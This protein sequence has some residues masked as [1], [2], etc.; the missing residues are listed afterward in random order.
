VI[1]EIINDLESYYSLGYRASG[2]LDAKSQI[3]VKV[4]KGL[5][6]R[7]TLSSGAVSRDWEVADQVLANHVLEPANP[8]SISVV[9]DKAVVEGDKKT[10]P[11]KIM[12]PVN[13]LKLVPDKGEYAAAFTVFISLGDP[14]GNGSEPSRQEQSFRWPEAAVAQVKGKTIGFAVNLE[15]G[16]DRD[17]V[18]V[19]V[20]D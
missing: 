6:A 15:V 16:A 8:L 17:R 10:I 13:S 2:P 3:T 18:S 5:N 4:K 9:L 19:G 1:T 11:M 12:I 14:D 20:L 7:T